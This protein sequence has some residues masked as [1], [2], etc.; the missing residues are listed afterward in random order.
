MTVAFGAISTS[1]YLNFNLFS[2]LNFNLF[3]YLK[4][5]FKPC[6][7]EPATAAL[8]QTLKKEDENGNKIAKLPVFSFLKALALIKQKKTTTKN[9][10]DLLLK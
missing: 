6:L 8:N 5:T 2:Y 7:S 3:S 4:T 9:A 1:S 10:L